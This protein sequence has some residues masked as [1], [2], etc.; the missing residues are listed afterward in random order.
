MP[1]G[2]NPTRRNR[3]IGTSKQGF[4]QDNKLVIPESHWDDKV[5]FERI[6]RHTK[7]ERSIGGVKV[8]FLIEETRADCLHPCTVDDIAHLWARLPCEDWIGLRF[9][10]LRQ[11]TRKQQVLCPVWGRMVYFAEVADLVGPMLILEAQNLARPKKRSL[12]L[13]PDDAAELERLR[14]AG[15]RVETTRRAHLIHSDVNSVRATQLYH[16]VPHE[17]G[18]WVDYLHSVMEPADRNEDQ[19]DDFLGLWNRYW[20]RP[21]KEREAFAHRY[22]DETWTKLNR[23]GLVPFERRLDLESLR[24]DGLRPED[25]LEG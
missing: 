18:H 8:T 7:V 10:Y 22:A 14:E 5:Y 13:N 15:H 6:G 25:F 12:S 19:G 11:P 23:A 3:N 24:R 1:A 20:S 2:W 16:T 21:A 4:G 9:I 17:I